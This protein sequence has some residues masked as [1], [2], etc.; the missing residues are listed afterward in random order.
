MNA[1]S[2]NITLLRGGISA[3]R[4]V[5]LNTG[6]Q[7][8]EALRVAGHRVWESDISPT[9]LS[10]LDRQPCDLIFPALHGLFGEDG[11]LQQIL[12]TCGL[13]FVGSGAQASRLGMDKVATKSCLLENGIPTPPWQV[14][15]AAK[16]REDWTPPSTVGVPCVIKPI[17]EGSS[18]NCRICT[19]LT[20]ARTHLAA[21][22]LKYGTMLV[23]KFVN[24]FELTVGILDERTLPVIW[25]QPATEFYDYEAKYTRDDTQY[26]FDIPLPEQVLA[27]VC[28]AAKETHRWIGCRHL[29]RVDLMVDKK[30][31]EPYVL[32]INTMPGFTTHSLVPKAAAKAGITFPALCDKLA[33]LALRDATAV[34]NG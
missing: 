2:L 15:Y 7:I 33:K 32:E 27:L 14:V 28:R 10:A 12:E 24:G 26:V 11:Q 34:K 5:S 20:E 4:E 21:T 1:N 8:A 3:E 23:E 30:T 25:I 29:S 22:L 13:P 17:A 18:V 16:W 9:D 19:T 6:K 31:L